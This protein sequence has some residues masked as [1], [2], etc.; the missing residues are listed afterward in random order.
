[1]R[2]F[3]VLIFAVVCMASIGCCGPLGCGPGC[4]IPGGCNDCDGLGVG[5]YGAGCGAGCGVG[6]CGIAGC[7]C[8]VGP[9]CGP[10]GVR[11]VCGGPGIARASVDRIRARQPIQS[12]KRQLVCGSGCG[13]TYLGE[14]ISTPPDVSDPCYGDQFIGG[15]TKC[16]PFCWERGTLARGLF[17]GGR[18]CNSYRAAASCGCG[19][20]S[21]GCGGEIISNGYVS[22][23][24]V[25]DGYIEDLDY[26]YGEPACSTCNASD[27][28]SGSGTR[29]AKS[30]SRNEVSQTQRAQ[31]YKVTSAQKV[32]QAQKLADARKTAQAQKAAQVQRIKEARRRVAEARKVIAE[33]DQ[34]I[35]R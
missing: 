9:V 32:A 7:G 11:R 21:C 13:E 15:A 33:N 25:S 18:Y 24:Y 2:N 22:D 29:V 27:S 31:N 34:R 12:L 26:S 8:G 23:G 6:A 16:R 35:Y 1:M 4:G 30:Q 5:T 14:W 20:S 3:L 17:C 10:Y 19:T 28:V